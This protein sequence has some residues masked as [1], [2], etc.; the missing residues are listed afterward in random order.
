MSLK[1]DASSVAGS[2][3]ARKASPVSGFRAGG[4][5]D[6][7]LLGGPVAHDHRRPGAGRLAG[8][9]GRLDLATKHPAAVRGR[10]ALHING[11]RARGERADGG[12]GQARAIG[13]DI[14]LRGGWCSVDLV[15]HAVA[16]RAA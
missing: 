16:E 11:V 1:A 15:C 2:I 3:D 9:G 8:D 14:N 6:P 4:E 10:G 13:D 5:P 7:D 12:A